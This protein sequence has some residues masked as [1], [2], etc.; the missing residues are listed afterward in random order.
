MSPESNIDALLSFCNTT[1]CSL[2]NLSRK[3]R[4]YFSLRSSLYVRLTH[5]VPYDDLDHAIPC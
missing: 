1:D 5:F 3:Y 4:Y 2:N